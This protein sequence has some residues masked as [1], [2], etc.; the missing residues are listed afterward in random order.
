MRSIRIV[1]LVIVLGAGF[2]FHDSGP[3]Y[4]AIRIVY[5]VIVLSFIGFALYRRSVA[6]HHDP[7]IPGG[8][9]APGPSPTIPG[10]PGSPSS[11]VAGISVAVIAVAPVLDTVVVPA[12]GPPGG[13]AESRLVSGPARHEGPALLGRLGLDGNPRTGPRTAGSKA[14]RCRLPPAPR[15]TRRSYGCEPTVTR[16]PDREVV[17]AP[18]GQDSG[19]RPTPSS[20]PG[21]DEDVVE[22][23]QRSPRPARSGPGTTR[24]QPGRRAERGGPPHIH[25][26]PIRT[27][28]AAR[29]PRSTAPGSG[30]AGPIRG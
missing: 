2:V 23:G 9:P 8:P 26:S 21:R 29:G 17:R 25:A 15:G 13:R 16:G 19:P 7:T 4:T 6:R 24:R 12:A 20:T 14:D 3:T 28:G 10:G 27:A 11:P 30:A 18:D 22:L 1:L 5:F